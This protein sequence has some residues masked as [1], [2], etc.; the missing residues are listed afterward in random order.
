LLNDRAAWL[1]S[2]VGILTVLIF[3]I[4]EPEL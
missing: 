2:G 1:W 3:A 4:F